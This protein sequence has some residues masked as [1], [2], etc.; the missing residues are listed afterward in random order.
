MLTVKLLKTTD[1]ISDASALLY[2]VYIE[3]LQWKF[4]VDNPSSLRIE[5][6]NGSKVLLD[7]FTD[8]AL[9][10]G[11]FDDKVLIGC[12]RLTSADADDKFELES[13]PSSEVVHKYLP[14]SD[15]GVELSKIAI[16]GKY[17][18]QGVVKRM[19]LAAFKYCQANNLS[20][21]CCTHN[22]YLKNIF[23]RIGFPL[24]VEHAF[25]Y[26]AIDPLPV[27]L[28]VADYLKDVPHMVYA[29]ECLD[30]DLSPNSSKIFK[31]LELVAPVLPVSTYWHDTDGVVLGVNEHCLNRIGSSYQNIVGKSPYEF[32][33]EHTAEH[34]VS[35]NSQ[36]IRSGEIMTQE[37]WI[38]DI[39]TG[40]KKCFSS[41]KAPLYDDEGKII[42]VIGSFVEITGVKEAE[43]LR[44]ENE[45]HK[46][47]AE[48]QEKF[49]KFVGQIVHDI[50][51]PLSSL[52]GLINESSRVIPEEER[53][54]LRQASMRIS[55][56]AQ[57][58]LSRYKN[59]VDENE[60]AEAVLVSAAMLEVLGEKR[61]EHKEV[62][63]ITNFKP[64][65]DFAFI[66]IG[67]NQFKRMISNL[68]NN[69]VEA[70]KNNS[71]GKIDLR[72]NANDEWVMITITDNGKGMPK[73]LIDKIKKGIPVTEGKKRGSGIGLTQVCETVQRNFGEMEILSSEGIRTSILL[74]FPKAQPPF[75]I[76][77]EIKVIK[78]DTIVILDDDP[79]IHGAWDSRI[80]PS[81]VKI[82]ELKVRHFSEGVEAVNFINSLSD[83]EKINI[84]L[85][86]DYELLHQSINGL[87]VIEQ[88]KI[89][90]STL[91]T[92][93]YANK[94]IREHATNL[95]VKI[96]PKELAFAVTINLN[97]KIKPGS[98]KV[99]IVW[100]DDAR[101]FIRDWKKRFADLT[102]DAYY[103]PDSFLEDIDQYPLDTKIILDRNYYDREGD[104]RKF[105]GDGLVVAKTLHE[106]G[107]TKL[108][109][110]TGEEP[111]SS[112]IPDYLTVMLKSED[113]KIKKIAKL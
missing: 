86:T 28:Y 64:Q 103:E 105:L 97:K 31:A 61:Y 111:E 4:A 35:H 60:M 32:Y 77:E 65:A 108:F 17:A 109:M 82:P 59:E 54:T 112:I 5:T 24:I 45:K 39:T 1:L 90:R 100:V 56:I 38:E 9:W 26:E 63:F 53:I 93:H 6:K 27:N 21:I 49:K 76:A 66:Q 94:E 13:Y 47:A 58:M 18:G 81:L 102:I 30:G 12:M 57:H 74:K 67:P 40:A 79:S 73:E 75:W 36:V 20:V 89:K 96:L 3:E 78:G 50:Q 33:P 113:E 7:R 16:Q 88:T 95:R 15:T 107:Y 19:W 91:V 99:D 22:G 92:S 14:K 23:K 62:N 98:K 8:S 37:E 110:I 10:F 104:G 43:Q 72:L 51:S 71:D 11:A 85:L 80:A 2:Q 87:Q 101:W 34:I 48:E 44:I 25:K 106:K 46:V 84:C 70:L 41:T 69:A 68:L 55:D 83:K 52:R 42:G 29:L